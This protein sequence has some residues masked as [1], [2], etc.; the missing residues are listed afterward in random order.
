MYSFIIDEISMASLKKDAEK[1]KNVYEIF[2]NIKNIFDELI[3][4]AM[5]KIVLNDYS[6]IELVKP[7]DDENPYILTKK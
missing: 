7:N 4:D 2:T 1:M 3:N 5:L 6:K